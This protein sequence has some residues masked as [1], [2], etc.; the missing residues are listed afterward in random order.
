[1]SE[2]KHWCGNCQIRV[3]IQRHYGRTLTWQ[4]CPYVCEYATAMRC[5]IEQKR[6]EG[7][8]REQTTFPKNLRTCEYWDS[9][10][11][12]CALCKPSADPEPSDVARDI[13][14]IIENEIDM[15]VIAQSERKKGEWI[16]TETSYAD[17]VQ[18]ECRC[19]VCTRLSLRPL[20]DF[21]R[22]CGADMR[23][24]QE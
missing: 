17:G 15:R 11:N 23:G 3:Y 13:A 10:S 8:E 7:N 24:E 6:M 20:G 16:D 21:C 2:F 19:S 5:S 4:D 9:E 22:W 14:R 18:Q 1:M 12:Y